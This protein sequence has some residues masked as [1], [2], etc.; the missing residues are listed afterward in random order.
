MRVVIFP[1]LIFIC[2]TSLAQQEQ[3]YSNLHTRMLDAFIPAQL[4]D[5]LTIAP[6]IISIFDAD[7]GASIDPTLFVL[8]DL[9]I[10]IDT[11]RLLSTYPFCRRV[12]ITYRTLP[13]QLGEPLVRLDTASIRKRVFQ[14]AIEFDYTPYEPNKKPWETSGVRS[15]GAY[16]RGLSV[17]NSQN[18]VFNSN[19]NLQL[20]GKLGNDLELVAA[21]SDNSIPIQPDGNTRQLKEFDRVFIQLKRKNSTLTAGDYDLI[22]PSGYFSNYFKRLQGA[23]AE[24]SQLFK[25]DTASVRIAAALSRGK[26]ARQTLQGQEGNQGP[27]RLQGAEGERFI[28][29]MAGTEKVFIDGQLMRRGLEDDYVIDY[30]LGEV[31]FTPRRMI[32]KDSRIIIEFEYAVQTYQ[33]SIAALNTDWKMPA[34]RVYFNL[35]TEQDGKNNGGAQALSNNERFRLAQTGDQLSNAFASGID[36]LNAFDPGRVLYR[37]I[38]TVVCGQTIPVL[39]YST[40][41]DSARYAARFTEVPMGQGNYVL[42]QTAANGRVFRWSAPD[43]LTCLPTGNFEPVVKLIAPELK[44]LWTA[45]TNLKPLKNADMTAEVSLSNRD[46]NR[47]SPLGDSDN[48][49][50][51][52]FFQWKQKIEINSNAGKKRLQGTMF[53]NVETT[54]R[55]FQS[56]NPY[57][58]AEFIR[59]WN[60]DNSRD[61]VAE[62]IGRAGAQFQYLDW[63]K[64]RYEFGMF[65]RNAVYQGNRHFA[66]MAMTKNGWELI[67]EGNTLRSDGL[68]ESTRFQRPKFDFSKTI[69]TTGG[70]GKQAFLKAG[71]YFEQE[72]NRRSNLPADTLNKTSFWYDLTKFYLQ[73]PGNTNPWQFSA[74]ISRRTDRAPQTREFDISTQADEFSINGNWGDAVR[75]KNR[76]QVLTWVLSTRDLR[77]KNAALTTQKAQNTYLGKIDYTLSALKNALTITTNYEIGAG[78]SPKL[79]FNYLQVNPGEGTYTWV[80]RNRDSIL[81]VD[82]MEIA[83]FQDQASYVRLAVTTPEY[84]RTNYVIFNPSLRFEPGLAWARAENRWLRSLSKFSVQSNVQINRKTIAGAAQVQA[85]NPFQLSGLPDTVLVTLASG[86]RNTLFWNRTNPKWAGSIS[87]ADNRSRLAVTSGFESRSSR[88]I[89]LSGRFNFSPKWS[90]ESPLVR[91]IKVSDNQNFNNRDFYIRSYH[92]G[93]KL[94]WLPNKSFSLSGTVK[95]ETAQNQTGEKETAE[96]ASWVMEC[97]WSPVTKPNT[98]GYKPSTSMRLKGAF[99][100]IDYQ[101]QANT[102]VSFAMLDGLQ[103]GKNFVWSLNLD[104]Q[105]SKTVQLSLNYE[106]RKTGENKMIH[107]GRAQVRALF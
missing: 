13:Y 63:L 47:F 24:T 9:Y 35:Y 54:S 50:F 69:F 45:G 103:N 18:L 86:L 93:P 102:A 96:Q 52:A 39:K 82:E 74:W 97:T 46:F 76:S 88:E 43:P 60:T 42:L 105:L 5:S 19:L 11:A 95:W 55:T 1:V 62:Q 32:T 6:P 12:R 72:K 101:G 4:L 85:W 37:F 33:R 79:E 98:Q 81:T 59:D 8:S 29:V 16:T 25:K 75:K 67:A 107:V 17:G 71:I 58:P 84:I 10:R 14:D 83:V 38:D 65:N 23:M 21:L 100:N 3:R 2:N 34:G 7:T 64:F 26:F 77:I 51:A 57:R 53:C 28:I 30:N 49:G 78:Q 94:S 27:Y 104:R 56:L 89:N 91:E 31:I 44:Q 70:K 48:A 92:I 80:D 68:V 20:N 73:T 61:T 87:Q 40:N 22:R 36:T 90:I 41:A 66:S 106:G 15:S 99:T